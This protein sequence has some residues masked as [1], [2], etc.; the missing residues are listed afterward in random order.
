MSPPIYSR[1][2]SCYV[3]VLFLTKNPSAATIIFIILMIRNDLHWVQFIVMNLACNCTASQTW[4]ID[5]HLVVAVVAGRAPES[6]RARSFI[7]SSWLS[8]RDDEAA[9][10]SQ[11]TRRGQVVH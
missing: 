9:E 5:V 7:S 3:C 11:G 8:S 2:V 4:K 10:V 6:G 1:Y